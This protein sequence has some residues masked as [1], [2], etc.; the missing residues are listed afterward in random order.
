MLRIPWLHERTASLGLCI[1]TWAS[2][3]WYHPVV[4]SG[5]SFNPKRTKAITKSK[6]SMTTE[7][8]G[9]V[10]YSPNQT[11]PLLH[12]ISHKVTLIPGSSSFLH[13]HTSV[14][15]TIIII[16]GHCKYLPS[17]PIHSL[18][19]SLTISK[20]TNVIIK[21][22]CLKHSSGFLLSLRCL[23]RFERPL[24]RLNSCPF[25]LPGFIHKSC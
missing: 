1:L 23:T 9:T 21:F 3:R 7:M 17:T 12:L 13:H 19:Y 16:P 20:N 25:Q 18:H 24:S 10:T 6:V 11:P 22:P 8:N 14:Q 15:S 4:Q 2:A 5:L